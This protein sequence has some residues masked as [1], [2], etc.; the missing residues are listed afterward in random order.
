MSRPIQLMDLSTVEELN[1]DIRDLVKMNE[2]IVIVFNASWCSPCQRMKKA[3]YTPNT[4]DSLTNVY[5]DRVVFLYVDNDK[6][7]ALTQ[8]LGVQSL[9]TIHIGRLVN[10]QFQKYTV[11]SGADSKK[12][13]TLIDQYLSS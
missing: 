3:I 11:F 5:R 4:V 13:T 12:L 7:A 8:T 9:P 1:S 2:L 6:C 10:G